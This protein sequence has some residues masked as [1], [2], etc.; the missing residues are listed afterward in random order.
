MTNRCRDDEEIAAWYGDI[1]SILFQLLATLFA[2]YTAI[3]II[4]LY[5]S[6]LVYNSDISALCVGV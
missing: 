2:L 4:V 6:T 3:N 5:K 1:K